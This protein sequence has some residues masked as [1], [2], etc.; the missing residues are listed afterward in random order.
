MA[1]S[2]CS[3][4]QQCRPTVSTIIQA[5]QAEAGVAVHIISVTSSLVLSGGGGRTLYRG[6]DDILSPMRGVL[7]FSESEWCP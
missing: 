6:V 5:S 2:P 3:P 4:L 7:S 1:V